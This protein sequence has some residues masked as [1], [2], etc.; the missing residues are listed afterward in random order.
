M[1]WQKVP[2]EEAVIAKSTKLSYIF[3]THMV[4]GKN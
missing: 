2:W 4:E 3:G 1:G